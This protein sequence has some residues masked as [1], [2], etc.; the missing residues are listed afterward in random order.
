MDFNDWKNIG[1]FHQISSKFVLFTYNSN[2][3]DVRLINYL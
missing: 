2:G 1:A 3:S